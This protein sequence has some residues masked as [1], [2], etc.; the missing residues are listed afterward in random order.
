MCGPVNGV[1]TCAQDGLAP[2][3]Y[4]YSASYAGDDNSQPSVSAAVPY[5]VRKADTSVAITAHD[6]DPS[7]LGQA[8][9]VKYQVGVV[10]PG[11]GTPTG[12]VTVSDGSASCVGTMAAGQCTLTFTSRGTKDL[13]ATYAGDD[14]FGGK[15]S[16]SVQH[17]VEGFAATTTILSDTPD[18]S[19][20]HQ[21]VTVQ[22]SVVS[23]VPGEHTPTG[24]VTV[25]D[26]TTSCTASV[27]VGQCALT[28]TTPGSRTLV[29]TY[30]GDDTF[31]G[32][33]SAGESHTI[34]LRPTI[35]T[36]GDGNPPTAVVGQSV[37]VKYSVAPA[38]GEGV[39]TG[40]VTV[41]DGTSSCT[42][43][44]LTGACSITFLAPGSVTFT[45]IY[46]GDDT[47]AGSISSGL[48]FTVGKADTSTTITARIPESS[49]VG[50]PVT[51]RYAVAVITP[52]LGTPSRIGDRQRRNRELHR[53][54]GRGELHPHPHRG[55]P[56]HPEG[57]LR[58]GC[59]LRDQH[60]AR[61][62][63]PGQP[64]A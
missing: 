31:V 20:V 53:H 5:Q 56:A 19:T 3:T 39:P 9:T 2:G 7:L 11:A 14:N 35:T 27:A 54:R 13:V 32:S 33:I 6:P 38:S 12:N 42:G 16:A 4:S 8:V 52:G 37:T 24:N 25:G 17:T 15:S 59:E 30:A 62:G 63:A 18:P 40:N 23:I 51:V 10:A 21:P 29:A 55:R 28:F 61:C 49:V 48:D 26:G 60:L 34:V 22:F 46:A 41:S 36:L 64:V 44:V 57:D 47:F 58:R 43:T 45:A 50:Q 1:A